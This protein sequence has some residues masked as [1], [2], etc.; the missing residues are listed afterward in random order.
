MKQKEQTLSLYWQGILKTYHLRSD[1]E[2]NTYLETFSPED[3]GFIL[4][5]YEAFAQE[6]I[7]KHQLRSRQDSHLID[8]KPYK[9]KKH[10][11]VVLFYT[12]IGAVVASSLVL[13]FVLWSLFG[14]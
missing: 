6:F 1:E 4:A 8:I 2:K 12:G 7:H 9:R 14:F 13:G 5:E 11:L 10:A 3:Q